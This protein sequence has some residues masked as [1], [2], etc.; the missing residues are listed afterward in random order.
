MRRLLAT[1]RSRIARG[2]EVQ[3]YWAANHNKEMLR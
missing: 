3:G 2:I 1:I